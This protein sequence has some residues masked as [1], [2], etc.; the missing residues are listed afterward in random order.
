[1]E[2]IYV[3]INI[4]GSFK[5]N[6]TFHKFIDKFSAF[7][8]SIKDINMVVCA[9]D[10]SSSIPEVVDTLTQIA[11]VI[12]ASNYVFVPGNHDV[13]N[14]ET[15]IQ[16][17]PISKT[18][19]EVDI[20]KAIQSTKFKYLP[21]NPLI[22]DEKVAFVG[23]IGWYDYSFKDPKWDDILKEKK[24]YYFG[25]VYDGVILTEINNM[26]YDFKKISSEIYPFLVNL[27]QEELIELADL[28]DKNLRAFD[29]IYIG[30]SLEIGFRTLDLFIF[31]ALEL[32]LATK[33]SNPRLS[34]FISIDT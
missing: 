6:N 32:F 34:D 30:R 2:W 13:W 11:E 10:V 16:E 9:G 33:D 25:K 7:V 4:L 24:M 15:T 21:D 17:E 27:N 12:P 18:K 19:Y 26:K 14:V 5:D 8:S 23:N 29:L 22:I 1:M 3:D 31:S 20:P 28:L